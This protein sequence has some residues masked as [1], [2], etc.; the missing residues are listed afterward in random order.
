MYD[1]F[2]KKNF[3]LSIRAWPSRVSAVHSSNTQLL[4]PIYSFVFLITFLFFLVVFT[5][6]KKKPDWKIIVIG[7]NIHGNHFSARA[8]TRTY[9][10][11]NQLIKK[12]TAYF[13]DNGKI[14][15]FIWWILFI[16]D[17]NIMVFRTQK[18]LSGNLCKY[19]QF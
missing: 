10:S 16:L 1:V 13:L 5:F 3:F 15:T 8:Q 11:R 9:N 14:E 7:V 18:T 2:L 12:K 4:I 17:F 6:K 19:T